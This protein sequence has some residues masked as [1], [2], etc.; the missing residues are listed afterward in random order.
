MDLLGCGVQPLSL[1][2]HSC[3]SFCSQ[4]LDAKEQVASFSLCIQLTLHQLHST[5]PGEGCAGAQLVLDSQNKLT[6]VSKVSLSL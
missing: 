1:L 2:L 4:P 5:G 6:A 3:L